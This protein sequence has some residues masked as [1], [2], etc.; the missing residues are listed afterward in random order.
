[1]SACSRRS[2]PTAQR[3]CGPGTVLAATIAAV[4]PVVVCAQPQTGTLPKVEL[5][6]D[7]YDYMISLFPDEDNWSIVKLLEQISGTEVHW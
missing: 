1:M 5:V 4:S 2:S 6:T 3:P 7:N